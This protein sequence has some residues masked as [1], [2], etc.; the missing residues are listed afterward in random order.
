M[1][2]PGNRP[3]LS[4]GSLNVNGLRCKAKRQAVFRQLQQ[5]EG[6]LDILVLQ[7]T[8]CASLAEAES[9]TRQGAGPGMPWL[10]RAAWACGTAMS[11]GVAILVHESVLV[12]AFEVVDSHP[13]G[14]WVVVRLRTPE[15]ELFVGSVYAPAVAAERAAFFEVLHAAL[16]RRPQREAPLL[17][18]GDWNCVESVQ[19]D[20]V[21]G[22]GNTRLGGF[23][24]GLQPL[25]HDLE[26]Q[27]AYRTAFPDR[28]DFTHRSAS[29]GTA[30]RLDRWLVEAT[31]MEQVE[32]LSLVDGWPGDHRLAT[33]RLT[34]AEGVLRGPGQWTFPLPLLGDEGFC[35]GL[36]AA[37]AAWLAARPV[38]PQR[39]AGKRWELLKVYIKEYTQRH[40]MS[41]RRQQRRV[42][43]QL[44][45]PAQRAAQQA[46]GGQDLPMQAA[47]LA[48]WATAQQR[49]QERQLQ[50]AARAAHFAGVLWEDYGEGST[51]WFHRLGR[52]RRAAT[53]ITA[54]YDVPS[55]TLPPASPAAQGTCPVVSLAS[56]EGKSRAAEL[57]A[58]FYD[59]DSPEGLFKVRSTDAVVAAT[60]LGCVDKRLSDVDRAT[61]EGAHPAGHIAAT[62]LLRALRTCA[63]GKRPGIDGLPYEVYTRFWPVLGEHLAEVF[64][65][66]LAAGE[67]ALLPR[68]QRTGLV[69]LLHKQGDRKS[70]TNYRPITLLCC[71]YKILAKAL[72][73]RW[74]G[75]LARTIDITQTAFLPGRWIGDNVLF[76]LEEVDYLDVAREPGA[77]V[78]CDF[79]KAYD[80]V[81]RPWVMA[82]MGAM[83]FGPHARAWAGLL[84]RETLAR[85]AFN[86]W[87]TRHFTVRSGVAQ[88]SPLS[89]LLYVVAAQPLAA[90]MRYLQRQGRFVSP[91]LPDGTPAPPSHQHADDTT[92]H[93][94][95]LADAQ[96]A[97]QEGIMPFCAASGSAANAGKTVVMLLG[98]LR[99]DAAWDGASFVDGQTGVRVAARLEA[100]RHLGIMLGPGQVGVAARE[101]RYRSL[102]GAIKARVLHWSR[103][104]LSD[105]GRAHIAKQVLASKLVYYLY[106]SM[107]SAR[108]FAEVE[109]TIMAFVAGAPGRMH[110]RRVVA[111]LP[112]N[113][114]GRAVVC[115]PAIARALQASIVVRLLMPVAHPWKVLMGQWYGRSGEW[116]AQHPHVQPRDI[117]TLGYGVRL[118]LSAFPLGGL[119]RGEG[120]VP[121]RVLAAAHHLRGLQPGRTIAPT[122]LSSVQQGI[123]PL[124]FN[125]SVSLAGEGGYLLPTRFGRAV[126]ARVTTVS[127]LLTA[128]EDPLLLQPAAAALRQELLRLRQALPPTWC[129]GGSAAQHQQHA[130]AEWWQW[131]QQ[132]QV[133]SSAGGSNGALLAGGG[134]LLVARRQPGG[135]TA[136]VYTVAADHGLVHRGAIQWP[137]TEGQYALRRPCIVVAV[138]QARRHVGA[139]AT[140]LLAGQVQGHGSQPQGQLQGG[141]APALAS[142]HAARC[143]SYWAGPATGP[144]AAPMDASG[145][146]AARRPLVSYSVRAATQH[147]IQLRAQQLLASFSYGEPLRP[148][149]W[150]TAQLDGVAQLAQHWASATAASVGETSA[151]Q[152]GGQRRNR[153]Q[154]EAV[155]PA[156]QPAWMRPRSGRPRLA[157]GDRVALRRQLQEAAPAVS[158]GGGDM[159]SGDSWWRGLDSCPVTPVQTARQPWHGVWLQ[160]H[161]APGVSRQH[162][163]L[164]WQALHGALPCGAWEAHTAARRGTAPAACPTATCHRLECG[165]AAED[166][167]HVFVECPTAAAVLQWASDLWVAYSGM[168]AGPPR[169]AAVWLAGDR[170]VWDPGDGQL[171]VVWQVLRAACIYFIWVQRCKAR[172]QAGNARAGSP[173]ATAALVVAY[174]R[175]CIAADHSRAF[176]SASAYATVAGSWLPHRAPL[177]QSI[178]VE[179]WARDNVLCSISV[180]SP[181]SFTLHLS[182]S[183]PVPVPHAD[184]SGS[185]S[186]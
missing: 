67:G 122:E 152:Q 170:A 98:S 104:G 134:G 176:A 151:T 115:L 74:G 52:E 2:A 97:W 173:G 20:T 3:R 57:I 63:R 5:R 22:S 126:A 143:R 102:L 129:D 49:L 48:Q 153:Q 15:V 106:Y 168:P 27:D 150:Q 60:V 171:W 166:L 58:A 112:W 179:R 62:E 183:H 24:D 96:R 91:M 28:R 21:G 59:G 114:G 177:C 157:P 154:W 118:V 108:L 29:A 156:L 141:G 162:R 46:V 107:P 88:G 133:S 33:M 155:E 93:V 147:V 38:T 9:W 56:A 90:L 72:A 159:G 25:M 109:K 186:L 6:G 101:D 13:T 95:S 130:A 35:V 121:R 10:G 178:F 182:T 76:H 175:Q 81:Q 70:L 47:S 105:H 51:F 17:L 30:A 75:P 161:C 85:C 79:E 19:L 181:V 94:A 78:F 149:I 7:E 26:L 117:D 180:A 43:A 31:V 165:A 139:P 32:A 82:C 119:A 124:F 103:F 14:R 39:P 111:Q 1:S 123:E 54:L 135:A 84:H 65:E 138:P 12:E 184:A 136:E 61:C 42:A 163:M 113:L 66:A 100:V 36:E 127:A 40:S 89:P 71:D 160:L 144:D 50:A 169:C 11:S 83:G 69:V 172:S 116:L 132:A 146:G 73:R 128:L 137:P 64:N 125:P 164:A 174:L 68:C 44:R 18:G 34:F 110:P 23:L 131:Q 99:M 4:L 86:G 142:S 41:Q 158:T 37:I 45:R 80:R 8:H 92:L 87:R 120:A 140:L 185:F 77:V 53:V 148:A 16:P 145:W 167:L 55:P